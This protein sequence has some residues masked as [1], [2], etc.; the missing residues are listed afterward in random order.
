MSEC[1]R[2]RMPN[3]KSRRCGAIIVRCAVALGVI[4]IGTVSAATSLTRSVRVPS[5]LISSILVTSLKTEH[6]ANPLGI[7]SPHPRFSWLIKSSERGQLQSAY[8][9]IVATTPDKLRA[10]IGDKWDSGKV[11]SDNSVEV[12]YKGHTLVTG[13]RAYWKV[14]IWD[15]DGRPSAY[16][17]FGSFEMGLLEPG[18]WQGQWIEAPIAET[19]PLFRRS[20]IFDNSIRKARVYL[21]GLGYYELSINGQ[22]VGGSVL[23]PAPTDYRRRVHYVVYDV[24]QFL[25]AGENAIGVMLGHG[26][27]SSDKSTG[28]ALFQRTAYGDRPR[29]LFQMNVELDDGKAVQLTSDGSWRT[30]SGPVVYNDLA[31]GETYDARLDHDGWNRP[32]YLE[33]G[34]WSAALP[35][36]APGGLLTAQMV[37][38]ER[39]MQTLAVAKK[40]IPKPEL[41]LNPIYDFG[42]NF[43]GWVRIE[44]SGTRGSQV[45]L[46]YAPNIHPED[47]TLDDRSVT[48]SQIWQSRQTD[49]YI[50][51]GEG[52][53]VWEPHFTQH[54][55]RYVEIVSLSGVHKVEGRVVHT[56]IEETGSFA[57]SNDLLNRIHQN[58]RWTL[59]SSLHGMPQDAAE[60]GERVAWLGDPGFVAE[61]YIYN[62]DMLAFWEK[63]LDDIRDAQA[64]S[65]SVAYESPIFSPMGRTYDV[66]PTWQSTYP[67]VVWYLYRYYGD[68]EVLR[69]HYPNL[70][71]LVE[72]TIRSAD[73]L[74]FLKEP[75]GDHMEPGA[76]GLS[77]AE[78]V[79]TPSS[80]TASAYY[81]YDVA[82]IGSI[83]EALGLA[84]DARRYIALAT[85]IKA[86]FNNKFLDTST[87]RYATNSQTS[88]ALPLYMGMV[89]PQQIRGVMKNLVDDIVSHDY[90]VTT[91]IVGTNALIQALPR[92][93]ATSVL[94]VLA[95]QT[96]YPSLGEQVMKGATTVCESYECPRWFS[97]NMKMLASWDVFFHRDLAG[98]S[99]ASPGYRRVLIKPRPVP[100]LQS[101]NAT[102]N[103][104]RGLVSVAWTQGDAALVL[105][106]SIPAGM[107]ADI[108][109]PTM[110]RKGPR[111]ADG[112]AAVWASDAYIP[113]VPGLSGARADADSIVF[114]AGSGSYHFVIDSAADR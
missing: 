27:Y 45:I 81:Y 15:R 100:E 36:Q 14:R 17:T 19:A 39:V 95:N 85:R 47:D 11:P 12:L 66:W 76:D 73:G 23:D 29:V 51:K 93:G 79:H 78:S 44:V 37:P 82:L 31:N 41:D 99:P 52:V 58:I 69:E 74:L 9:I 70:K 114:H 109:V 18:D 97:Q 113:G 8:Q 83:A 62:Y 88:N 104:V 1:G 67:L 108:A 98:I 89:P 59:M 7:Q 21:S 20:V 55:F 48:D 105:N 46:R 3:A 24:T 72:F 103:T 50:L 86:A 16:S 106:V 26:W 68:L 28:S 64:E 2:R 112:Q 87:R 111:I 75:L 61:D 92:Y 53:E 65:G 43:S 56:D 6:L 32:G 96:T 13:E 80:L 84:A 35:A 110:G 33:A 90:H 4:D 91:G 54:G 42:Q 63:W 57:S 40:L 34:S 49:T 71:R 101:V 77:S 22:K 10:E 30:A 5:G 102:Q 94:Y 60:R 38:A 107:E 25:H